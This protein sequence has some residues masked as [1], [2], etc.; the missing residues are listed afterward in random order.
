MCVCVW[1]G[2]AGCGPGLSGSGAVGGGDVA[3]VL[4]MEVGHFGRGKVGE[5]FWRREDWRMESCLFLIPDL[6]PPISG[7]CS[8]QTSA[9]GPTQRE[10]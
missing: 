1:L 3:W 6:E 4:G 8:L 5:V 10:A 9:L 7:P 2:M